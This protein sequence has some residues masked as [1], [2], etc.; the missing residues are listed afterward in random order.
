MVTS[1]KP[2]G[3]VHVVHI[4]T[5]RNPFHRHDGNLKLTRFWYRRIFVLYMYIMGI[6]QIFIHIHIHIVLIFY[7][8]VVLWIVLWHTVRYC[9]ILWVWWLYMVRVW[10]PERNILEDEE[11]GKL[12]KAADDLRRHKDDLW[13]KRFE[14]VSQGLPS[15]TSTDQWRKRIRVKW[16]HP[17]LS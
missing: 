7:S 9:Q 2:T 8:L 4:P 17:H 5:M 14:R 16:F 11:E 13:T 1:H 12:L 15:K 3:V 10:A 6:K